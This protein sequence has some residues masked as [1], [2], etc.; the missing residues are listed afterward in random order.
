MLLFCGVLSAD[1]ASVTMLNTSVKKELGGNL[2]ELVLKEQVPLHANIIS[3]ENGRAQLMLADDSLISISPNTEISLLDFSDEDKKESIAINML[4][5]TARM[6]TGELSRKNP[7]AFKVKTPQATI[8]IRGTV[9]TISVNDKMTSILL[10]Q[11]SGAGIIITNN[12]TG[13]QISL[14]KPGNIV[15]VENATLNERQAS[16]DEAGFLSRATKDYKA[17]IPPVEVATISVN[18]AGVLG[19]NDAN[20]DQMGFESEPL[21]INEYMPEPMP[22]PEPIPPEPIPPEPI[23]NPIG[24]FY[25]SGTNNALNFTVDSNAK[26]SDAGV[27]LYDNL[28]G[29][30]SGLNL[31]VIADNGSGQIQN[32]GAF[33]IDNFVFNKNDLGVDMLEV[34]GAFSSSTSGSYEIAAGTTNNYSG[35]LNQASFGNGLDV[36]FL[37]KMLFA[38]DMKIISINSNGNG[39]FSASINQTSGNLVLQ[40]NGTLIL[41]NQTGNLEVKFTSQTSGNFNYTDAQGNNIK[42]TFTE[43]H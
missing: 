20:N 28:A 40:E 36:A 16:V 1:V 21:A 7:D 27:V 24:Y 5:G 10:S 26:I 35:T 38:D 4:K 2:S 11:T 25:G 17:G 37:P 42:G 31:Q 22:E 39:E 13:E 33:S 30:T 43:T 12:Q 34:S 23:I 32:G 8:G 3:D 19:A 6:V 9:A 29:A 18:P 14:T 41:N 15:D